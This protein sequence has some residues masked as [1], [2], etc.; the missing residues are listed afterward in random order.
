MEKCPL[1][2]RFSDIKCPQDCPGNFMVLAAREYAKRHSF[3]D[4]FLENIFFDTAIRYL[5]L[6]NQ[7]R[8]RQHCLTIISR[9]N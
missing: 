7:F 4:P 5:K 6:T 8:P 2:D 3:D 9:E 1:I